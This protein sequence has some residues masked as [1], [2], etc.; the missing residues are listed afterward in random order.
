MSFFDSIF[1]SSSQSTGYQDMF[2]PSQNIANQA[3]NQGLGQSQLAN[4]Q[5]Q[6]YNAARMQNKA[7]WMIDGVIYSN[8]R[9]FAK[10]LFLDDEEAVMMFI[11]K[12]GE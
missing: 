12:Y 9:E 8:S 11:L 4:Q 6:A 3:Y 5:M 2:N 1:G 7:R 10:A